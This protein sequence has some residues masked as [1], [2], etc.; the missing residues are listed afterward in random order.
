MKNHNKNSGAVAVSIIIALL[1]I[2][3]SC[4]CEVLKGKKS[5]KAD[6]TNVKK[7]VVKDSNTTNAGS[8]SKNETNSKEQNEWWRQTYVYPQSKDSIITNNYFTTPPATIIYEGGRGTKEESS[9]SSDSSFY[10][11]F[12]L[13]LTEQMDST[14]SMIAAQVKSKESETKGVGLITMILL[15][16]GAVLLFKALG[17]IGSKYTIVKK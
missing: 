17:L 9:K 8:V 16:V 2:V 7:S 13:M 3:F 5:M 11:Q 14:R 15:L 10:H 12:Q 1:F 6:S 4:G